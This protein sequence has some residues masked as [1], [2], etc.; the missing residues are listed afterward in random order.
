LGSVERMDR[1]FSSIGSTIA[2]AAGNVQTDHVVQLLGRPLPLRGHDQGCQ[3]QLGAHMVAH[4]P[5]DDLAGRQVKHGSEI[6]PSLPV[7]M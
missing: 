5:S 4:R 3:R 6:Q 2:W 7:A 1:L